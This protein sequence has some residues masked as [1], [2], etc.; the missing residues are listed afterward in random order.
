MAS[1]ILL[2]RSAAPAAAARRALSSAAIPSNRKPVF[3]DG[4]RIPFA[5]SNT[6]YKVSSHLSLLRVTCSQLGRDLIFASKQTNC[7]L[8]VE[9]RVL[10][11]SEGN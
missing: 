9:A 7:W 5:M 6:I 1:R 3:I 8:K 11:L 2:Q 10:T 4:A